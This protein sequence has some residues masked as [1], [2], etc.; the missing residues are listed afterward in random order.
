MGL[1]GRVGNVAGRERRPGTIG[2]PFV[3]AH[4]L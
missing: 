4:Y 2:L 1:R 3:A